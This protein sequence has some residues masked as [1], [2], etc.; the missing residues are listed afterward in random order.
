MK[1][2]HF[3]KFDIQQSKSVFRVG[4]DAVLL[5]ALTNSSNKEKMLE[6]GPGTGVISL[7][8]AQRNLDL[9]ITAVEISEEAAKLTELNFNHSDFKNRLKVIQND[10]KTFQS[11][12]KFDLIVCNPP[13]FDEN[14]STKDKIA[15]QKV[16]LGFENLIKKSAEL[17]TENGSFSV[18]LPSES[19][20]SFEKTAKHHDFH[21]IRKVNIFGIKG[22]VLKR[23]ILEF[24]KTDST[25][26][27]T[28]FVIESAPRQYSSQ[29]L[30]VTKDFHVFKK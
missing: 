9:K 15:R 3:Q 27:Q 10:F 7:M 30:E 12:E 21:L 24:S 28:D 5:G 4:T 29:Y 20:N 6:I 25:L 26:E 19:A 11:E 8:L 14:P 22:G 17:I 18:I 23:N 2:F 16:E 13:Y 1:T